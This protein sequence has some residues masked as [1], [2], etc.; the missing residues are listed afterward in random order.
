MALEYYRPALTPLTQ[1]SPASRERALR[2]RYCAAAWR[3]VASHS[4]PR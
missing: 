3:C 4:S 1:P 2:S